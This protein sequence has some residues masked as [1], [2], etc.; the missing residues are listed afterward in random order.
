VPSL[1]FNRLL[2]PVARLINDARAKDRRAQPARV[3][4]ALIACEQPISQEAVKELCGR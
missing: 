1:G 4:V 3:A 2:G